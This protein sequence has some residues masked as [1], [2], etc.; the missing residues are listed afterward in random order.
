MVQAVHGLQLSSLVGSG[1]T[2]L[3]PSMLVGSWGRE[4]VSWH[5]TITSI[6]CM[7]AMA[8]AGLHSADRLA[9]QLQGCGRGPART[10]TTSWAPMYFFQAKLVVE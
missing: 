1:N 7:L 3:G 10:R 8:Y 5:S 2:K 9:R 4:A 6:L